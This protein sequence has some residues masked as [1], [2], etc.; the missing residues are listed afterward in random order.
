[1]KNRLLPILT[2]ALMVSLGAQFVTVT[3]SDAKKKSDA[4]AAAATNAKGATP[5][6]ADLSVKITSLSSPVKAGADAT[7]SIATSPNAI[8]DITVKYKSGPAT[9][10]GLKSQRAD[11]SGKATWTWKVA[12]NCAIGEWP[13]QVNVSQNRKKANASGTLKVEK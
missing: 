3:S 7:A 4:P 5:A 13:V 8:C 6:P 10:A 2:T 11:A 12:K 1:M 9:A